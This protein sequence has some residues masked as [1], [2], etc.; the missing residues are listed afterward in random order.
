MMFHGHF[1]VLAAL[2]LGLES[3]HA[4]C[5]QK[6]GLKFHVAEVNGDLVLLFRVFGEGS[7]SV[8]DGPKQVPAV[9]SISEVELGSTPLLTLDLPGGESFSEQR[10][11][12]MILGL[13][14]LLVLQC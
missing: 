9:E 11:S 10:H 7:P 4:P 12:V 5:L 1:F 2:R 14:R 6:S 3:Q 13:H 8:E